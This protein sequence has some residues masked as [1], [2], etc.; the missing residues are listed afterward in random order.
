MTVTVEIKPADGQKSFWG[1]ARMIQYDGTDYWAVVSYGQDVA[2]VRK[3]EEG[4][5]EL[6]RLWMGY[7]Q[8]TIRHIRGAIAM[9][10][11]SHYLCK[12]EWESIAYKE[13]VVVE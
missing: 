5:V 1:N 12:K 6:T 3:T 4:M 2:L 11:A 8:T 13:S 9:L 7:A 10:G